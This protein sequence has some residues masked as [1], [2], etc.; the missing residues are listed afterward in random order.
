MSKSRPKASKEVKVI[1]GK[2]EKNVYDYVSLK[3]LP[4]FAELNQQ[5]TKLVDSSSWWDRHGVDWMILFLSFGLVFVALFLMKSS[6]IQTVA[7]GVFVLGC[8]HSTI[9]IKTAHL[10]QHGALCS[11][12]AL[13]T[14][15]VYFVSDLCGSFSGDLGYDIHIKV[16]HPHTNIIGLGDSSTWKVPF[17]P[18]Y[19]YMF[20]VPLFLPVVTIPIV[21]KDIWGKWKSLL[22][23][24]IL[25]PLG[26]TINLYLL[27]NISGFSFWGA[28]LCTLTYRAVLAIPY[29]HVNIF[30][31]I[32]L[33]MY[34]PKSRPKR[35]YQ[36]STGVLNLPRNPF[37]DYTFGHAI[38]SC[39]IEH[40]LFPKLS[41]NMC[42]KIKPLV[43]KFIKENGLPY[44]EDTYM[45][46][47]WMFI[48]QYN[49][50]MVNAP[51]ISHFV[52]IQ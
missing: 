33:A 5:V 16:H 49:E 12:K 39:H 25:M 43:T 27:M 6:N 18:S 8:C 26:L 42:L 1:E 3:E 50:L 41:D 44:Y 52:G 37:L 11:S 28:V 38:V 51:P 22:T 20:V 9:A 40:H 34:S 21:L 36:M 7:L 14:F 47:M 23:Y 45:N 35:I 10:V 30:Q 48:E 24:L 46:R 2:D 32:G 4:N 15:M 13:G 29:I 19:L 17:V 31:H